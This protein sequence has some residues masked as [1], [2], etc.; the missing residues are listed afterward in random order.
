MS[1]ILIEGW[2]PIGSVV[3]LKDYDGLVLIMA[4]MVSDPSDNVLWDYGAVPYPQ[5]L[6]GVEGHILFDRSAIDDVIAIGFR[7]D[8][9]ELYRDAL[10]ELDTEF[11]EKKTA[12]REMAT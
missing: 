2:L 5:G 4:Y 1:E 3:H 6:T 11:T 10:S 9:G 7:N 12:S 8:E